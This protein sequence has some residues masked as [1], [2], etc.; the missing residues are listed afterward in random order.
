M[1]H[2]KALTAL[3]ATVLVAAVFAV[4]A[5]AQTPTGSGYGGQAGGSLGGVAGGQAG[6]QAGGVPAS[7]ATGS[8]PFTGIDLALLVVGGLALTG[9]GA[10]LVRAGARK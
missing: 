5:L 2:L 7:Q 3:A 6:A 1:R 10:G 8:L 4:S 9:V